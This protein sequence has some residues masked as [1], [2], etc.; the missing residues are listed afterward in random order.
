V[1]LYLGFPASSGEP[2][3]ILKG[4]QKINLNIGEK[5]TVTFN[6]IDRDFSIWDATAHKWAL[7]SGQFTVYVG[8][9]S[10]DFRLK[11]TLTI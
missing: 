9:S 1:Q 11:G 3:Y 4:F 8:A 6:P 5:Q 2:P 7:Q 10:A